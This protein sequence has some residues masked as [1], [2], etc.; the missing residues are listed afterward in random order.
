M[1]RVPDYPFEIVATDLFSFRKKEYILM[2]DS[3]SGYY[4]FKMLPNT[5]SEA[6]IKFLK[7]KFADH[8]IPLEVHS[9]GGPQFSSKEFKNFSKEWKFNH[10]MSSPYFARS[11]GLAERYVQTAKN[12][13]KK[14]QEDGQDVKMALLLSR[15]TPGEGLR[16]PAERLFSRKT[17]NPLCVNRT[18]LKPDIVNDNTERL[19][20]KRDAQKEYADIGARDFQE[21]PEGTRVRVQDRDKTWSTGTVVEQKSGRSY[22]VKMD[23]GRCV[24][25][26]RH[27]LHETTSEIPP[28]A[29][30]MSHHPPASDTNSHPEPTANVAPMPQSRPEPLPTENSSTGTPNKPSSALQGPKVTT[31]RSG[32]VVRPPN[33]LDLMEKKR[34]LIQF[35]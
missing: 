17:R 25:R 4:D 3:F 5:T 32:R 35:T 10:I 26:N 20:E 31:T 21:L 7:D 33:R 1:K 13:L 27:F 16:S 6:V 24:W 18:L 29:P 34:I 8:G 30:S 19:Q 14:C 15:N 9:D 28:K 11:N 22:N 12:L 23:D 2:V